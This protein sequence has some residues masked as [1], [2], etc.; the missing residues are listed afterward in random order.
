MGGA[1]LFVEPRVREKS[2]VI[3]S[4]AKDLLFAIH[5]CSTAD[6]SLRSG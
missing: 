6:P 5:R 2:D 4:A 3:L 1:A